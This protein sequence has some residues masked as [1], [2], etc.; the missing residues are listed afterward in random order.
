MTKVISL[1]EGAYQE[2]KQ[3]KKEGES[4]SDVVH[5]VVGRKRQTPLSDLVGRWK[6]TEE[7][8]AALKKQLADDRKKARLREVRF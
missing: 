3:A 4:F 6:M 5:R 7:E 1:S 2:L 8:A